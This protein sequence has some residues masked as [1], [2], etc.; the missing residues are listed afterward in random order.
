[1][2]SANAKHTWNEVNISGEWKY[3]DVQ[4]YGQNKS[5]F[6]LGNRSEYGYN[7]DFNH[8]ELTKGGDLSLICIIILKEKKL[9]NIMNPESEFF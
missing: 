7:S 6:W 9:L 4:L 2:T 5:S 8:R 1:V 3:Y